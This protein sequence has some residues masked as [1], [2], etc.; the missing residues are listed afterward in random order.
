MWN[1]FNTTYVNMSL[2]LEPDND[3]MLLKIIAKQY[4]SKN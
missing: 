3:F 1:I 2:V 4:K